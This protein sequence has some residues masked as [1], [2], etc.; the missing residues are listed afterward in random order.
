MVN[1]Y[2]DQDADLG[3]LEGKTIGI[4]GYGSQGHAHALNLRDNGQNVMVGLYA[5]SRSRET[6]AAEGLAVADVSEVTAAS[7]VVMVLIPDHVQGE[8]YRNEI[9]PNLQPGNALM[10]AHGFSIHYREMVP[11]DNVDVMMV[12]PKAP[13]HRMRELFTEGVGVPGLLAVHQDATGNAKQHRPGLRQGRGLHRRRGAGD[14][15]QGR[16]GKRPVRRAEHPLRRR[17]G[18]GERGLRDPG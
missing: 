6:A 5:G 17:N 14:H 10:V 18:P 4:I 13:G 9:A 7:D 8:T 16:N 3:A 15:H 2:Y 1:V 12:A 11:P